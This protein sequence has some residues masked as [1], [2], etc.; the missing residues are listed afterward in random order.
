MRL[1]PGLCLAIAIGGP[2]C[3]ARS[4]AAPP[5]IT[6]SG[7]RFTFAHAAAQTIAVAGSFNG[8]STD[9][10]PLTLER[11]SGVWTVVVPLPPGEHLFMF[12]VD[13]AE[14]LKPPLADGYAGDGFGGMNGVVVVRPK[15]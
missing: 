6:A 13:G 5:T 15:E 4:T 12:V 8:W 7:V 10:H 9:A 3:A 2:G 1:L 11:R 14:W